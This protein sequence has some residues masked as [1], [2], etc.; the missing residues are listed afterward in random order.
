MTEEK[1]H[2]INCSRCQ[3]DRPKESFKKGDRTLKCCLE[4]RNGRKAYRNSNKE[5]CRKAQKRW[6]L[7]KKIERLEKK[8][9]Q[10]KLEEKEFA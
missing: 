8:L 3:K 2:T 7:T 5:T 6:R 1:I 10:L 9:I 4:C